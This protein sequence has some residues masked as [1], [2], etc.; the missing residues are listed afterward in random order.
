MSDTTTINKDQKNRL[1]V[2]EA[3]SINVDKR[4]LIVS[5]K[6]KKEKLEFYPHKI[7]FDSII[8][9]G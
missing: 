5:N 3:N 2:A 1:T 4:K 7:D 8:I 9:D 6:I